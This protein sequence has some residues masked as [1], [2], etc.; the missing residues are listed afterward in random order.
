MPDGL[1]Y[2]LLH[3]GPILNS[4]LH[5]PHNP[6]PGRRNG[7]KKLKQAV[8]QGPCRRTRACDHAL[9]MRGQGFQTHF[10]TLT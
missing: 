4:S 2:L 7:W 10:Y 1:G 9:G 6:F 3:S 8:W 5:S